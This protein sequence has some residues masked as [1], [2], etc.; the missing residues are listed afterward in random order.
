MFVL[1]RSSNS[2]IIFFIFYINCIP[3]KYQYLSVIA[4]VT[5]NIGCV[6]YTRRTSF[7]IWVKF[8]VALHNDSVTR[9]SAYV[10]QQ[11]LFCCKLCCILLQY[12]F[13]RMKIEMNVF[14]VSWVFP[15]SVQYSSAF[16]IANKFSDLHYID[17]YGNTF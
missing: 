17:L 4:S 5:Q 16:N 3:L 1:L 6:Q 11:F 14:S 2:R 15:D 8:F 13:L 10:A 9:Q 7:I 12:L